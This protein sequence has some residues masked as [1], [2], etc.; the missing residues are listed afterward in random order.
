MNSA[1][2]LWCFNFQDLKNLD[3]G[4]WRDG[5]LFKALAALPKD[6]GSVPSTHIGG[7]QVFVTQVPVD[8][9]P[10]HKHA[11]RTNTNAY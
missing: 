7:S 10:S 8:P 6:P 5:T 11:Y 3:I 2:A 1:L 9:T 4:A